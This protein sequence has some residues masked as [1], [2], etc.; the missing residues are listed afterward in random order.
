MGECASWINQGAYELK[1]SNTKTE[2]VLD[3]FH[4]MQAIQNI[5]KD[6]VYKELLVYYSINN[7]RKDFKRIIEII[8]EDNTDRIETIDLKSQ[9]ILKRL[10]S[11]EMMYKVVKIGCPVEQAISHVVASTFTS[12][13]KAYSIDRLPTYLNSRQNQQNGHDIRSL[14][15]EAIKQNPKEKNK[16]ITINKDTY[17]FSFLDNRK[18]DYTY[19]TN[20]LIKNINRD[21]KYF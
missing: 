4:F 5:T 15:F 18:N 13:P 14:V 8:K 16:E 1:T 9:Y 20:K 2:F 21:T 7:M 3:K 12:V 6:K 17:D 11:I 19:R 10:S